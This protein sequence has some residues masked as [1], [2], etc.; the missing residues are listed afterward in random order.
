MAGGVGPVQEL[1]SAVSVM[2]VDVKHERMWAGG[3]EQTMAWL[4]CCAKELSNGCLSC[5]GD[6][7]PA[8]TWACWV[9]EARG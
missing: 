5:M 7:G 4:V 9:F 2:L 3:E 8:W 1:V 6:D